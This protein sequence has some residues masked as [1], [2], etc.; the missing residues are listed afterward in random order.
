VRQVIDV[1]RDVTG[2]DIV[3]ETWRRDAPGTRP[4][5]VADASAAAGARLDAPQPRP[6][7]H[8]RDRLGLAAGEPRGYGA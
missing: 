8:R 7:R 5:L 1:A 4:M 3:V 2:R 6:A